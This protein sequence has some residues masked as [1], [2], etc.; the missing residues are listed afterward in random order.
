[1][2]GGGEEDQMW[3][4]QAK[5]RIAKR[6]FGHYG[7]GMDCIFLFFSALCSFF[8]KKKQIKKRFILLTWLLCFLVVRVKVN[9][10]ARE[11]ELERERES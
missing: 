8:K 4:R 6:F 3:W 9:A 2:I 11:R 5:Y 7:N 1:M 10:R